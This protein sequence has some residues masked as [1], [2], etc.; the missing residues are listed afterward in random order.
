MKVPGATRRGHKQACCAA[1]SQSGHQVKVDERS[2]LTL[3]LVSAKGRIDSH[4][5][6]GQL[7]SAREALGKLQFSRVCFQIIW[8]VPG[9]FFGLCQPLGLPKSIQPP[10]G[11]RNGPG[12]LWGGSLHVAPCLCELRCPPAFVTACFW[13]HLIY[14]DGCNLY[15]PTLI[16]GAAP[17]SSKS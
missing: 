4:D 14:Q 10:A 15:M 16:L 1:A 7:R 13:V 3:L 12:P 6:A 2:L 11:S 8:M 9:S 17:G 5:Y